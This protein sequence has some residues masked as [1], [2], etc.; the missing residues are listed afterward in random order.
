MKDTIMKTDRMIL[1]KMRR[2]DAENLLEIFSDPT[3]MEYY[4]ST[5]NEK[6]TLQWIDW[7]LENY[8]KHGTGPACGLPNIN[9]QANF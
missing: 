7:T 9:K 5:K 8:E 2:D 4:P 6:Q 1:R 3:A